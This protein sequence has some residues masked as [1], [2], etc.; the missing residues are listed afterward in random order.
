MPLVPVLIVAIFFAW[1]YWPFGKTLELHDPTAVPRAVAPRAGLS[2]DEIVNIDVYEKAK[3]SVVYITTVGYRRDP[4]TLDVEEVPEGTG[5]GFI[6]DPRG[7]VV[8]N[9]HVIQD[10]RAA[11]VHMFDGKVYQARLVGAA[12]DK[13]LA[14][15][16]IDAPEELTAIAVGT[17]KDV[18][19]GQRAYALGN[20]FGVGLTFTE[21]VVSALGRRMKAVTGRPID[22]VI[23]TSAPI[24]PG[25]S[26]GPLL[27]SS[28]RLI[29]VNTAIYSPSGANAGIGFAIPVDTVNQVIPELIRNG[30]VDRP[31]LG[32][33]IASAQ[34]ARRLGIKSGVLITEVVPNGAA[35]KAGVQ[36]TKIDARGRL[37]QLGD[38]VVEV[39][40][41]PVA[42]AD[43]LFQQLAQHKVGSPIKLTVL[44]NSERLEIPVT[45]QAI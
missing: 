1:W 32:V 17:S 44:R 13:D 29:G 37:L 6:W 10:A 40:G 22:D 18:R 36:P 42:D 14:V 28:A 30:K 5:S 15:L 26:G 24:N 20:P 41:K 2:A 7:Y 35:A 23:Q 21:G 45:L 19:V 12:P 43:D 38:V 4:A 31:G 3:K 16:R 9:F 11:Q 8:T 34:A 39:D 27:D 25:N 33:Q